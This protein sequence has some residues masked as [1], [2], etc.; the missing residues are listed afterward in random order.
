MFFSLKLDINEHLLS[1]VLGVKKYSSLFL[2]FPQVVEM[3]CFLSIY[4]NM[5]MILKS[6]NKMIISVSPF[7]TSLADLVTV[8]LIVM[9]PN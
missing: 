6:I 5:P 8:R 3:C 2:N 4:I 1:V 9:Q 7:G